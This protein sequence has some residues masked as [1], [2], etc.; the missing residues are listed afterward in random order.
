MNC[1]LVID[2]C[3]RKGGCVCC[4]L[5]LLHTHRSTRVRT[6]PRGRASHTHTHTHLA[7]ALVLL[8]DPPDQM[9]RHRVQQ[10][11]VGVQ[12]YLILFDALGVCALLFLPCMIFDQSQFKFHS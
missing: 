5:L 12:L 2:V 10:R 6:R 4:W 7:L 3:V 11:P 8:N 9:G 1:L